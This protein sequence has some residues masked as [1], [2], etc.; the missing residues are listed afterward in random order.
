VHKAL[1][2]SHLIR[3]IGCWTSQIAVLPVPMP[4]TDL[5]IS[6]CGISDRINAANLSRQDKFGVR[7]VLRHSARLA[8]SAALALLGVDWAD[9]RVHLHLF[10]DKPKQVEM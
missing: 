7:K 1:D 2:F 8:S 3:L 4:L 9:L 5:G 10:C 6:A